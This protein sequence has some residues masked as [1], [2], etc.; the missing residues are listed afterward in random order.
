VSNSEDRH[1]EVLVQIIEKGLMMPG[2]DQYVPPVDG[3]QIHEGHNEIVFVD[4]AS[5][6]EPSHQLAQ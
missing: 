2:N 1:T 6:Q 4:Q 5:F 3:P